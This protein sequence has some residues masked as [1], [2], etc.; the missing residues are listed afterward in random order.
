MFC[1]CNGVTRKETV[2]TGKCTFTK[3][4]NIS[5]N[6]KFIIVAN[7]QEKPN[8]LKFWGQII[9]CI[10]RD[11]IKAFVFKIV[12]GSMRCYHLIIFILLIIN[13][14]IIAMSSNKQHFII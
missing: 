11:R 13:T 14:I 3:R 6:P 1:F 12:V 9:G 2:K 8:P 10:T 5:L 4:S 7:E